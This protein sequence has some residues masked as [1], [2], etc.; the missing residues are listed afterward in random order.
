MAISLG[1][2]AFWDSL[3]CLRLDLGDAHFP[4]G[5]KSDASTDHIRVMA[6]TEFHNK[7]RMMKSKKYFWGLPMFIFAMIAC[8]GESI[9]NDACAKVKGKFELQLKTENLLGELDRFSI[10]SEPL[11]ALFT[12]Q[13]PKN[14]CRYAKRY[15]KVKSMLKSL[16]GDLDDWNALIKQN[17]K[18]K[19]Y[20]A[21]VATVQMA[22]YSIYSRPHE[23][24]GFLK[25]LNS[26][27]NTI[28]CDSLK[29]IGKI[30]AW[31]SEISEWGIKA[32]SYLIRAQ[33]SIESALEMDRY[34][35]DARILKA[36]L[37]V[38][39]EQ[40][41]D[42][43]DLFNT[44]EKE[45]L[46]KDRR[47]FLNTWQAFI[48]MK[49]EN[50]SFGKDRLKRAAAISEPLENATWA[51]GYLRNLRLSES[52]WTLFES[53][54]F[55]PPAEGPLGRLKKDT[56]ETL[57]AITN[58][59]VKPLKSIPMGIQDADVV[60][61]ATQSHTILLSIDTDRS[62]Q[63]LTKYTQLIENLYYLG[64]ELEKIIQQWDTL[65]STNEKNAYYYSLNKTS[66]TFLVAK[67]AASTM[68]IVSDKDIQMLLKKRPEDKLNRNQVNYAA[69]WI[70]WV[71]LRDTLH[72]E[73]H[74]VQ[75]QKGDL[76]ASE[77]LSF[78]YEATFGDA[79]VALGKLEALETKLTEQ[80][81]TRLSIFSADN[82]IEP[83]A[84]I[85][86]WKS[87]LNLKKGNLR[88]AK[89]EL[90]GVGNFRGFNEWKNDYAIL[91]YFEESFSKKK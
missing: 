83:K 48:A 89:Q 82:E 87:F 71:R 37:L 8:C 39:K 77:L 6:S 14:V 84:Y 36:Q 80:K 27:T 65:A 40:Y 29:R 19:I 54:D 11:N 35:G 63:N 9:V 22:L 90:E 59:M 64:I 7:G 23:F 26:D 42:A 78:E 5:T 38:L 41:F 51:S 30:P 79:D 13:S 75:A 15:V 58:E 76:I 4:G 72:E 49:L 61:I 52:K 60:D 88:S 62:E 24:L 43:Q 1:T 46:F 55:D 33:E 2:R 12:D 85:A 57:G 45:G 74:S 86:A 67:M 81:I 21:Y 50:A 28:S 34:Y 91:L 20:R 25:I 47:S 17:K 10:E 68:N 32:E 31:D 66:C 18:D 16:E 56:I 3:R 53:S 69:K 73:V 70:E 44:L